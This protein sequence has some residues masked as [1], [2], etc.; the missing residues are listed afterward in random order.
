[1]DNLDRPFAGK[2][3]SRPRCHLAG[4]VQP[5]D[6]FHR[7]SS[8]PDGHR[9][10]CKECRKGHS[11]KNKCDCGNLKGVDSARCA[12]CHNPA[13]SGVC[14]VPSCSREDLRGRDGYCDKH[15]QRWLKYGDP[16][17]V[18]FHRHGC[19]CPLCGDIPADQKRCIRCGVV[20]CRS[21][22]RKGPQADG[23]ISH[24]ALCDWDAQLRRYYQITLEEYNAKLA[25][26]GGGCAI[27][28]K[29]R[30]QQGG[31][32]LSVDHSHNCPAGHGA[33]KGCPSCVRGILCSACNTL[34]GFYGD[35][36]IDR[37]MA[38]LAY[39]IQYGVLLELNL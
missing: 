29:T 34:H 23:L 2:M 27:C 10:I 7:Q 5:L 20:K 14:A 15:Y 38:H 3:C 26:Q 22:F 17:A 31:R 25:A 19:D 30:E 32:A 11:S 12:Q 8:S 4:V 28:G 6:A 16:I 36:S 21:E 13:K 24:C 1:M 39:A 18:V 37:I 35:G 9:S 33:E